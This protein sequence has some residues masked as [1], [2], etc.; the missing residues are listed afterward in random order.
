MASRRSD[1]TRLGGLFARTM[2]ISRVRSQR[3]LTMLRWNDQQRA[4]LIDKLA[5]VANVA[6]GGLL[7]GQFL[8]NRFFSIIAASCGVAVW[9]L[10]MSGSMYLARRKRP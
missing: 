4:V 6:A 8:S 7:F 10:L 3:H 1:E 2:M 5:D 9:V